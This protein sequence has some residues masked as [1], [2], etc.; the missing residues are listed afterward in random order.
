MFLP[1][2]NIFGQ[3]SENIVV[4]NER[5]IEWA[6]CEVGL[7]IHIDL[8][9]FKSDYKWRNYGTHPDAATFNPT[10]LDTEQWMQAAKKINAKYIV[11]VAKH[12]SGFSLWPTK[13]HKFSVES[14]PW[15]NGKGDIVRDFV[16]SCRKNG[17]KPAIYASANANGYLF[18]DRGKINKG[19]PITQAEY[20]KIVSTQL[21]ELWSNYGELFEVWFD[22][23]VLSKE[24]GGEKILPLLKKL[25]PNAIAFQGP[26]PFDNLIRWVGNEDGT[27][28]YPCWSTANSTTDA[29]GTVEVKGLNGEPF[30]KYWCPGESD[31]PLRWN[32]AF[33][34]GWFWKDGEDSKMFTVEQLMKK[35]VTSVGRNTNMLVGIVLDSRGLVPQADMERLDEWGKEIQKQFGSPLE[36]K[37]ESGVN[38]VT[39]KFSSPEIVDR[40]IIQEDIKFGERV[41]EYVIEGKVDGEW[42][43]LSKGI[44]VGHKRIDSFD[45]KKVSEL[46]FTATKTKAD[47]KIKKFVAFKKL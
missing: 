46:R 8:Q 27:A 31:F 37:T 5:Q 14:S 38:T 32:R 2:L 20:G 44:S 12:C 43:L 9:T 22:G 42:T 19:A 3:G 36:A 16:D 13:A 47:A 7:I 21:E 33:Q 1:L 28:P 45:A 25:Q 29:D 17:I 23:G 41:L 24:N 30:A 34:G 35:Y 10:A 39:I 15:K 6:N 40:A 18:V 11:F 4:P 26:F